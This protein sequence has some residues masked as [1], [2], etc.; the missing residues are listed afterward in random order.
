MAKRDKEAQKRALRRERA[1]ERLKAGESLNVAASESG[2]AAISIPSPTA[3]VSQQ[4]A[5]EIKAEKAPEVEPERA[6]SFTERIR[7]F[8][9]P[10]TEFL[11]DVQIEA[12]KI[13]WPSRTETTRSAMVVIVSILFLALFMGLFSFVFSKVAEQ[14]FKAPTIY[15]SPPAAEAGG[16]EES[17]SDSTGTPAGTQE[18]ESTPSE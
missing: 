9:S 18:G 8:F 17:T 12:K 15:S 2:E 16:A 14:L 11:K 13:I 10:I 6:V 5:R 1:R 3:V 7:D 4:P